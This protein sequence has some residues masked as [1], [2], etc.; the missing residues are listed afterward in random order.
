MRAFLKLGVLGVL[1][2]AASWALATAG[3]YLVN[4]VL[5]GR[6]LWFVVLLLQGA[7]FGLPLF[8]LVFV[9][10]V[11]RLRRPHLLEGRRRVF[12]GLP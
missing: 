5:L 11:R 10:L 4:N 6:G 8:V 3:A 7:L 2:L 9:W 12:E 1:L